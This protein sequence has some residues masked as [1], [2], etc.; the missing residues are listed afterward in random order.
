M[1]TRPNVAV[2]VSLLIFVAALPA[3]AFADLATP[4]AAEAASPANDVPSG[5]YP[6]PSYCDKAFPYPAD[7]FVQK[8][9]SVAR[10]QD[11]TKLRANFETAFAVHLRTGE[12]K[13]SEGTLDYAEVKR[14]YWYTPVAINLHVDDRS[15]DTIAS[16]TIGRY[17][18]DPF[19]FRP[20][21]HGKYL[22]A[23]T[24][25]Q[26]LAAD[27]WSCVYN[28]YWTCEYLHS[29]IVLAEYGDP[30]EQNK[31]VVGRIH[32]IVIAPSRK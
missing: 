3:L 18:Q 2:F 23:K 8:L 10:Q 28:R 7:V 4:Q 27:G 25:E 32:V 20:A 6:S 29:R 22:T 14:C 15:G 19:E 13:K 1:S 17:T 26:L 24:I 30:G 31:F 21:V 16:I 5:L 11:P 12:F 9:V